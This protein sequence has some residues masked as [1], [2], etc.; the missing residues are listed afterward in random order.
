MTVNVPQ[1]TTASALLNYALYQPGVCTAV[2]GVSSLEELTANLRFFEA[3]DIEKDYRQL[4][5]CI[6]FEST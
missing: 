4:M 6:K 1:N 3:T 2:T 5:E